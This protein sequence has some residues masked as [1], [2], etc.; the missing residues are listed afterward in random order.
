MRQL[1]SLGC[2]L[3][4]GGLAGDGAVWAATGVDIAAA[5]TQP[6]LSNWRMGLLLCGENPPGPRPV[7]P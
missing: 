1:L 5:K 7:P 6:R 4:A 3:A 2:V